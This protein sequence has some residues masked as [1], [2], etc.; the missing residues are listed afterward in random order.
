MNNA[1]PPAATNA[2]PGAGT[3]RVSADAVWMLSLA[4]VMTATIV[5]FVSQVTSYAS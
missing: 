3:A 1:P 2:A 4:G 5:F